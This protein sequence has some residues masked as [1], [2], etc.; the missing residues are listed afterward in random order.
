MKKQNEE[1]VN[2]QSATSQNARIKQHL[3]QGM[4]ITPLEALAKYGC[5]RLS[6]RIKDL[7]DKY[8]MDIVSEKVSVNG[9]W[10]AQYRLEQ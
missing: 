1:F 4:K 8:N 9:K 10:V 7:K 3:E 2:E 6:A 5:F